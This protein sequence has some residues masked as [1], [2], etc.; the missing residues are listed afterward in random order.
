ML[1]ELVNL[2]KSSDT[3]ICIIQESLEK[4]YLDEC[5]TGSEKNIGYVFQFLR[6]LKLVQ[7]T[8]P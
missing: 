7:N 6:F 1:S 3:S 5:F 8:Y 4:T 2:L